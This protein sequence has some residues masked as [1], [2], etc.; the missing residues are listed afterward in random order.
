MQ[1]GCLQA[2]ADVGCVT[3]RSPNICYWCYV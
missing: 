2:E 3:S 1:V